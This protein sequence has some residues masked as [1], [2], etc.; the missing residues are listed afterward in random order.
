MITLRRKAM[1]R[2]FITMSAQSS[3]W[4]YQRH[5]GH[6]VMNEETI[7]TLRDIQAFAL[8]SAN[9]HV[10]MFYVDVYDAFKHIARF[11]DELI[12]REK[13]KA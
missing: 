6:E 9:V 4:L 1:R 11:I 3:S 13:G 10:M 5:K 8:F 7:D 12:E 2:T